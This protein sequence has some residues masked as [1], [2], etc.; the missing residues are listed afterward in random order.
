MNGRIK[1]IALVL[2][3]LMAVGVY[4]QEASLRRG[5]Y[6]TPGYPDH[7]YVA[8][9]SA[10]QSGR[11]PTPETAFTTRNRSY[12]ILVW[13]GMPERANLVWGGTGS[14]VGNEFR[15]NIEGRHRGNMSNLGIDVARGTLIVWQ[16]VDNETFT[17]AS[18]QR[19]VWRRAR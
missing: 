15:I 12:G 10:Y 5:Y 2:F 6:Q 16:I 3:V 19:W 14:I 17:D 8:T 9:N 1:V 18:G 11:E 4:A 13:V 7:V